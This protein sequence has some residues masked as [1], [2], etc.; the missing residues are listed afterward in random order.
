MNSTP[1]PFRLTLIKASSVS[2]LSR[3]LLSLLTQLCFKQPQSQTKMLVGIT[4]MACHS[5][6]KIGRLI[7]NFRALPQ[8]IQASW[9]L[10]CSQTED[11]ISKNSSNSTLHW[12]TRSFAPTEICQQSIHC[13]VNVPLSNSST[14]W[15]IG[16]KYQPNPPPLA[17]LPTCPS[18][19]YYY[20]VDW[21]GKP[22]IRRVQMDT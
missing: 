17:C 13:S 21:I 19:P 2:R 5:D 18:L 8:K 14:G 22:L 15:C 9:I 6:I 16:L 1:N 12:L 4:S 3:V 11:N 20:E 7:M 10:R